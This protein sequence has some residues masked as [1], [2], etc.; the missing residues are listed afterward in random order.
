[1]GR[2]WIWVTKTDTRN[3]RAHVRRSAPRTNELAI[4]AA[5]DDV[6][7]FI[8]IP[9][10]SQRLVLVLEQRLPSL[11]EA[12]ERVGTTASALPAYT[13]PARR[14]AHHNGVALPHIPDAHGTVGAGR[15]QQARTVRA[16]ARLVHVA[17]AVRRLKD[18]QRLVGAQGVPDLDGSVPRGCGEP[19]RLA[20]QAPRNTG[21]CGA[22]GKV[23]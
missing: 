3:K 14:F 8:A 6:I 10:T 18:S 15:Q 5:A 9:V 17:A 19:R 22:V 4:N 7:A 16:P 12:S 2:G 21:R 23:V 11:Q 13:Q 20:G 1:M